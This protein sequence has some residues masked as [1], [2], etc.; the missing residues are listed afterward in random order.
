MYLVD[1]NVIIYYLQDDFAAVSF[2]NRVAESAVPVYVAGVSE[3]ELFSFASLTKSDVEAIEAVV[4]FCTTVHT[5]PH[6]TRLAGEIRRIHKVKTLDALIAATA[7]F[8]GATLITRNVKDFKHIP[9]LT[10]ELL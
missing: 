5:N 6:I 1:T 8:V 10:I 4:A 7:L 3:T 2:F 9:G